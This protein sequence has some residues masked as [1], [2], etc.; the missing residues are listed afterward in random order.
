MACSAPQGVVQLR[1][2]HFREQ[3]RGGYGPGRGRRGRRGQC[4]PRPLRLFHCNVLLFDPDRERI[5]ATAREVVK[6]LQHHGFGARVEEVNALEA[7][8]G[9]LPG[10]GYQNVRKPLLHTLNLA[11]LLPLTSIWPGLEQHPCPFY[12]SGSPSL[13]YA[14]TQGQRRSA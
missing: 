10:H 1:D 11:D 8:L 9:S 7:Y 14:A 12:P 5:D 3:G 4:E 6:H 2:G 13:C